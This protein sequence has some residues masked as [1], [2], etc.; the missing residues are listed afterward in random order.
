MQLKIVLNINRKKEV[1]EEEPVVRFEQKEI[2]STEKTTSLIEIKKK[3][4]KRKKKKNK[5]K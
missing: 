3:I 2:N 4:K 1:A 5:K